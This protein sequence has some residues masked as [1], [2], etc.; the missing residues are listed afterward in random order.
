MSGLYKKMRNIK[1][2]AAKAETI[3]RNLKQAQKDFND[4]YYTDSI[5]AVSRVLRLDPSHPQAH[6]LRDHS[7]S[8]KY[9]GAAKNRLKFEDQKQKDKNKPVKSKKITCKAADP[10]PVYYTPANEAVRRRV[11]WGKLLGKICTCVIILAV[12]VLLYY[13][14]TS[15]VIPAFIWCGSVIAGFAEIIWLILKTL[16]WFLS[17]A[18]EIIIKILAFI[19]MVI[20]EFIK[21]II[22]LFS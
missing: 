20:S 14:I 11:S 18:F 9:N 3:D 12:L 5:N 10:V 6:S 16:W 13:V 8:K 1:A 15:F 17:N 7:S 22:E 2:K 4:G 21:W 19:Y